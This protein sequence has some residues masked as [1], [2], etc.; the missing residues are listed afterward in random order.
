[1]KRRGETL[2][3]L[4]AVIAIIAILVVVFLNG[5]G[6][7]GSSRKD[8]LGSTVPGEVKLKAKDE[9]CRSNLGQVRQ[10]IQVALS[11]SE[12]GPP[13]TLDEVHAPA[14]ILNCPIGHEHYTYDPNTGQV[15]CPHPGHENY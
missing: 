12:G 1:M 5:G 4:L 8:G 9:E 6:S 7:G 2:V 3:G 14:G 13:S 15:H 10:F 11:T